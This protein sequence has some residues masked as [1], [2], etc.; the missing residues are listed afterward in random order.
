MGLPFI[1]ALPVLLHTGCPHKYCIQRYICVLY[2]NYTSIIIWI[3]NSWAVYS[4]YLTILSWLT[5]ELSNWH[6]HDQALTLPGGATWPLRP[7]L[8]L[9][10]A[11][12]TRSKMFPSEKMGLAKFIDCSLEKSFHTCIYPYI[13]TYLWMPLSQKRELGIGISELGKDFFDWHLSRFGKELLI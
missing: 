11:C 7:R 3:V 6:F 12:T 4:V 9:H 8:A 13:C 10:K 2:K 1:M 5:V